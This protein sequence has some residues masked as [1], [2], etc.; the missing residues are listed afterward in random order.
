MAAR[1]SLS[2]MT[3][4]TARRKLLNKPANS[5]KATKFY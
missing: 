3:T 1:F 4:P 5:L 2:H